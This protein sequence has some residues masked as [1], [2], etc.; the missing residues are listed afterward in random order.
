MD[1]NESTVLSILDKQEL[2]SPMAKKKI[3]NQKEKQNLIPCKFNEHMLQST[4]HQILN[5]VNCVPSSLQFCLWLHDLVC[6]LSQIH[7][8]YELGNSFESREK[9]SQGVTI[10]TR[11]RHGIWLSVQK[12][13]M[14]ARRC[15]IG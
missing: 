15:I 2:K 13:S 3:I 1:L 10:T 11:D 6:S 14:T 12:L 5:Y 9:E 4:S 8:Q 7:K